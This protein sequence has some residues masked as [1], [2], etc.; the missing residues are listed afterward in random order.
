[1]GGATANKKI[2]FIQGMPGMVGLAAVL[3]SWML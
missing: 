1:V 2:F 3:L